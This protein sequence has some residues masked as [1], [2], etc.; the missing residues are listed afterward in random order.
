MNFSKLKP[1]H[2]YITIKNV[3]DKQ[4][5]EKNNLI[6]IKTNRNAAKH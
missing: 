1:K 3:H 4:D 2:L 6:E 5:N